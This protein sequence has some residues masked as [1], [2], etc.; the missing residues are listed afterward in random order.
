MAKCVCRLGL[1]TPMKLLARDLVLR[2]SS[3]LFL[4]PRIASPPR[5]SLSCRNGSIVG[6]IQ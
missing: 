3:I 2:E 4:F 6:E 1:D 5:F